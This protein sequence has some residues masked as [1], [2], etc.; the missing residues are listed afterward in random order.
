[1]T[2]S[3]SVDTVFKELFT[4]YRLIHQRRWQYLATTLIAN[5]ASLAAAS[6][7]EDTSVMIVFGTTVIFLT[8]FMLQLVSRIRFLI[9]LCAVKINYLVD[10]EEMF[11][12]LDTKY[13]FIVPSGPVGVFSIRGTTIWIYLS[14]C[15]LTLP[16]FVLLHSHV[17]IYSYVLAGIFLFSILQ[18]Q[19]S[20]PKAFCQETRN[21]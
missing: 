2:N 20:V 13:R 9:Q 14:M 8:A 7:I 15:V 16:W 6:R 10:N 5:G 18:L 21:T 11:A 3:V 4:Q 19:W 12:A 1:M 17:S